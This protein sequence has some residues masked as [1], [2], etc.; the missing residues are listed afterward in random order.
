MNQPQ[1]LLRLQEIDLELM[2]TNA[3]LTK[4]QQHKR[5]DQFRRAKKKVASEIT[6]IVGMRKD[7]EIDYSDNRAKKEQLQAILADVQ[8]KFDEDLT[9]HRQIRELESQFSL[10]SK[11]IEKL[12]FQ[13]GKLSAEIKRAK[14][15][16]SNAEELS[17]KLDN[18]QKAMEDRVTEAS[19]SYIEKIDELNAE[20][21]D[22]LS[23]ISDSLQEDYMAANKKYGGL[24]VEQLN[25]NK[26]TI[27]RVS[28]QSSQYMDIQNAGK[29][30]VHCPYCKRLLVVRDIED[31]QE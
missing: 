29:D 23:H 6:K 27:C 5:L 11:R 26:P 24:A 9:D 31:T 25:G 13:A 3:E 30:I 14:K 12:D 18:E 8:S 20:R 7:F 10:L 17:R 15:A 21:T 2:R 28:L 4:I 22:V 19:S 1:A 16:Q